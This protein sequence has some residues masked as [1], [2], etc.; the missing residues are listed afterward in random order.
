MMFHVTSQWEVSVGNVKEK[1]KK[2]VEEK[3]SRKPYGTHI[4]HYL[5]KRFRVNSKLVH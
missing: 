5:W 2:I 3:F 4:G 1:R